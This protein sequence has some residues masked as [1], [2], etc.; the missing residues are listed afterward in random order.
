[1]SVTREV[2]LHG[3]KG[4]QEHLSLT[5][6][7]EARVSK[8]ISLLVENSFRGVVNLEVFSEGD[9]EASM[10]MLIELFQT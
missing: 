9:L 7:P 6:L 10:R 1:M 8:W 5:V 2:H 3:V 4:C